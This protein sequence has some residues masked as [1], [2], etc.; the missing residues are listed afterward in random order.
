[1]AGNRGNGQYHSLL[2]YVHTP[3][4]FGVEYG[5]KVHV[6]AASPGPDP[7]NDPEPDPDMD[8]PDEPD[9]DVDESGWSP[10]PDP[11]DPED[12]PDPDEDIPG[13]SR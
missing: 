5:G 12:E 8:P 4:R 13:L 3:P 10:T 2:Q 11:D 1:M 6:P 7:P 9:P